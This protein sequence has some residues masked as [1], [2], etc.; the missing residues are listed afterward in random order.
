MTSMA[1]RLVIQPSM[2]STDIMCRPPSDLAA[3]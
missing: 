1:G 3:D 2:V